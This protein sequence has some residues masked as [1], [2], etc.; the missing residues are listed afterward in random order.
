MFTSSTPS[1]LLRDLIMNPSI[2]APFLLL[3]GGILLSYI[4]FFYF[5][6][7]RFIVTGIL[8]ENLCLLLT[9]WCEVVGIYG[10]DFL[11]F[12]W[13][14]WR[15][16]EIIWWFLVLGSF[17]I[18]IIKCVAI[19]K[20]ICEGWLL[21]LQM[22]EIVQWGNGNINGGLVIPKFLFNF[23]FLKKIEVCW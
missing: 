1:N 12:D 14:N 4:I 7:S 22:M 8:L 21:Y 19:E 17:F 11:G 3:L 15:I 2:L 10:V 9:W 20:W 6:I 16:V 5:F 13:S 18:Y 23:L